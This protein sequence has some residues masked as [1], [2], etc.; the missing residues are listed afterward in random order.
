[1]QELTVKDVVV[2]DVEVV[3]AGMPRPNVKELLVKAG[4]KVLIVKNAANWGYIMPGEER[5]GEC[6][7][8]MARYPLEIYEE[9]FL[10]RKVEP[11]FDLLMEKEI[12][13]YNGRK[14]VALHTGKIFARQLQLRFRELQL[15][16]QAVLDTVGEAV[17]LI[18]GRKQVIAWNEC[19][20][21]L[22]GIRAGEIVGAPIE[23]FFSNL[24]VTRVIQDGRTVKAKYHRPRAG[25]HVLINAMPISF[26][27]ITAGA[28]SSERDITDVVQLNQELSRTN[29]EVKSLKEEIDKMNAQP[30]AF[31]AVCGHNPLIISAVDIARKVAA[32]N[33]PILLRGESGTGKEVF[34]RAIHAASRRT[35]KF[36]EIN[37]GAIPANLFESELFGYRPG[38]FTGADRKGKAGLFEVADGGTLFLDEIGEL[39][40]EMQ[41]KLLRVLQDNRFYHIGGDKPI[42]VNVRIIAATHRNLEEMIAAREFRDDLYYRLNVVSIVLPPLRERRED[43]PELVH[44]GLGH[45]G[46]MHGKKIMRVEPAVMTAFLDYDWPGNVRELYNVL[47]RLTVLAEGDVLKPVYLP[48]AL[49]VV[50][51]PQRDGKQLQTTGLTAMT[52]MME[53]E[54]I[55]RILTEVQYN[56]SLAAKKLGIPRSTLYYKMQ[57]LQISDG[58]LTVASKN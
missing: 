17:C 10:N 1:M 35:G 26:A 16:M 41:V 53:K 49:T 27:G 48:S 13:I 9:S 18:D 33:V 25:T 15:R 11:V 44:R 54:L 57:Q 50:R 29:Q 28:V 19:A 30:D 34:A 42:R 47:E 52:A 21:Q 38:A 46:A 22:Y 5:A 36:V 31:A 20:E 8:E 55:E 43:I 51:L 56:K 23:K 45:F 6:A 3:P 14:A 7:G 4:A 58:N 2:F 32:A 24:W 39:P 12:L 37:C 40:K